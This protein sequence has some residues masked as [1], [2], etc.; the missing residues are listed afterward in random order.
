MEDLYW[1]LSDAATSTSGCDVNATLALHSHWI[2]M[3]FGDCVMNL[4]Q[5]ISFVIGLLSLVCWIFAQ[6]P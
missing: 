2:L 5:Y 3:V 1:N 6:F 4:R